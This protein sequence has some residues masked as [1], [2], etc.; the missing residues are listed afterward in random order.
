[1]YNRLEYLRKVPSARQAIEHIYKEA[2][3]WPEKSQLARVHS[4][5]NKHHM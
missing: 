4:P 5:G 3:N 1:M 2:K